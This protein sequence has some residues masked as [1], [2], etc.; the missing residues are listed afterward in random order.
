ML[1]PFHWIRQQAA[2]AVVGGIADGIAAVTPPGEQPP[3][4]LDQLR[5][6]IAARLALPA[7]PPQPDD[8]AEPAKRRGRVGAS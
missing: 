8:N 1:N 3:A 6:L 7:A 5:G 4:D 2:T